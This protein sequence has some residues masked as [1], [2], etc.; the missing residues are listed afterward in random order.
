MSDDVEVRFGAAIA[1]AVAGIKEGVSVF[2][3]VSRCHVSY[4]ARN[5]AFASSIAVACP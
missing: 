2:Y 4:S 5:D 1:G 3:F